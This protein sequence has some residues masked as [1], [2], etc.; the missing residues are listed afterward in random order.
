MAQKRSS[1]DERLAKLKEESETKAKDLEER[2]AMAPAPKVLVSEPG[3]LDLQISRLSIIDF[4]F[5]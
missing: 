3:L 1:L 5:C 4:S 2:M